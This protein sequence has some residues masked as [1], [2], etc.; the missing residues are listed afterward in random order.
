MLLD[1]T[2][3]FATL[4]LLLWCANHVSYRLIKNCVL[5]ER[6]WDY[7]ICCGTTDGG[8][9]NAD[10]VQH[11]DLPRFELVTDVTRL[12]HADR[13]FERVLC[14]HTLEHVDD[15]EAMFRELR[16]VGKRVTILVPPLWDLAAALNPFEHR[17]IFLTAASRHDDR[18]PPF[19]RYAPARW[20]QTRLGQRIDADARPAGGGRSRGF[21][22]RPL[23]DALMPVAWGGAALLLVLERPAGPVAFG[24]AMIVWWLSKR[25]APLFGAPLR[26]TRTAAALVAAVGLGACESSTGPGLF[27]PCDSPAP[28]EGPAPLNNIGYLVIFEPGTPVIAETSRLAVKYNFLAARIF[29]SESLGGFSVAALSSR[30]V[31]GLRCEE[32]VRWMEYER[33]GT[34]G[35]LRFDDQRA[36][37][38]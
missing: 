12:A 4:V 33:V 7:N 9:I 8:G 24:L 22:L 38:Y 21:A 19:I 35:V 29:D 1:A 2:A 6:S 36:P 30:A 13:A 15:P 25:Q 28:L 16:R 31:A 11:A 10:I 23:F 32:S 5:R 34:I 3:A 37:A 17:V 20:I 27:R 14:S 18:L 26:R